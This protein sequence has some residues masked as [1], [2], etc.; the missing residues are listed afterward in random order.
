MLMAQRSLEDKLRALD[1]HI[2]LLRENLQELKH[3][4]A[5]LKVVAAELRVLVCLSS[6]TEGLLWRLVEELGVNDRVRVHLPGRVDPSHPLSQG[7]QFYFLPLVRAGKGD[8]R[9]PTGL[10]SLR[11]LMK[12][13]PAVF[14]DG[15]DLTFEQVIKAVAQQIGSAH[16]GEEIRGSLATLRN[17]IMNNRPPFFHILAVAADLVVEVVERVLEKAKEKG[18]QRAARQGYGDVSIT[19]RL[20]ILEHLDDAELVVAR[21]R[22]DISNIFIEFVLTHREICV[23]LLKD[24]QCVDRICENLPELE[25]GEDVTICFSYSSNHQKARIIVNGVA[26]QNHDLP[27]GLLIGG[28]LYPT[29]DEHTS[30]VRKAIPMMIHGRLLASDEIRQLALASEPYFGGLLRDANEPEPPFPK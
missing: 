8:P 11:T 1:D 13:D 29:V 21:L 3:D 24:G 12:E 2:F 28:E 10:R 14:V 23:R 9:V 26:G 18:F 5:R 22:S 20:T 17:I 16:E 19:M 25:V 7:L 4:D 30:R 6:G 27:I 15:K